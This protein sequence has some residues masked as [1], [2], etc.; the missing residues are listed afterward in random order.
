MKEA[1]AGMGFTGAPH[2]EALKRLSGTEVIRKSL[3]AKRRLKS[4]KLSLG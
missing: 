2:A 1:I 4:A 3:D